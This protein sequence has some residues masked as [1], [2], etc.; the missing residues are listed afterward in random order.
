MASRLRAYFLAGVLVTA[1]IAITIYLAWVI[2]ELID[3]TVSTLIPAPYNAGQYLPFTVPGLGVLFVLV[4]LTVIG[5]FTAGYVGK[6]VVRIGESIVERMPVVRSIYGALKQIFV[7]VLA[8]K[9]T[10]FREVVLLEYPRLGVWSLGFITGPPLRQIQE[11]TCEEVVNVFIPT[12][13]N[14]TSGY[15]LFVPRKD[16]IPLDMTIEE[17]LKML[18]S[19]GIVLPPERPRRLPDPPAPTADPTAA[20]PPEP[21]RPRSRKKQPV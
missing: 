11:L 18:I 14:P 3:N 10:A 6:L 21:R 8:N 2:V 13:P 4:A 5:M 16:M 15:L 12:T 17:G 1:P 9:S 19:G 20:P 7:T